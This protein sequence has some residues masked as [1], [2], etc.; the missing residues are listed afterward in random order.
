MIGI[1]IGGLAVGFG[2]I[3]IA[4]LRMAKQTD[5]DSGIEPSLE[6]E[7]R[8]VFLKDADEI[9]DILDMDEF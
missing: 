6:Q 3:M 4:L 9:D 7:D 1:I 8:F 5:I 2:V